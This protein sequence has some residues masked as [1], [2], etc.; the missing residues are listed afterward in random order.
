MPK[1]YPGYS[2]VKEPIPYSGKGP[3]AVAE[4][5]GRVLREN[6]TAQKLTIEAVERVI[7][8]EKLLPEAEAK[9]LLI[10]WHDIVRQRPM[11]EYP[12]EG[13]ASVFVHLA[14]MVDILS[15]SG[16]EPAQILVGDRNIFQKWLGLRISPIHPSVFGIPLTVIQELPSD[17]FVLCGA[18]SR[19]ADA[20]DIEYSLK[21]TIS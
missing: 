18:R 3:D 13:E 5:V 8:L 9:D 7:L 11:D 10:S 6:P 19:E 4:A 15:R 21:G 12:L 20:A 2:R 17:I 16:L 1:H 14:A